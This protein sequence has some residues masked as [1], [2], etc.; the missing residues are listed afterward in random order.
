[1]DEVNKAGKSRGR[2]S[3]LTYRREY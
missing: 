2:V 3:H 1:M